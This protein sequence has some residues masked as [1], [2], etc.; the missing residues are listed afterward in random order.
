MPSRLLSES[1]L[2]SDEVCALSA[3]G[4][5]FYRRLLSVVDDFG[6]YDGRPSI[7]RARL[8]ALRI[9][10]VSESDIDAWLEECIVAG[11][12]AKYVVD[13]KHYLL[14]RGLDTARAKSSKYPP[15]DGQSTAAPDKKGAKLQTQVY[16]IKAE[17]HSVVKIGSAIC[18]ESRLRELQTASPFCL[19][20]LGIEPGGM[21]REK[22]LHRQFAAQRIRL[23]GEW[24]RIE[25]SLSEYLDQLRGQAK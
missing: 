3:G 25:G 12:V 22:E 2:S 11:L 24:F 1:I 7:L 10:D 5:V 9:D 6:R 17:G 21:P 8:Y 18:P 15:P 14:Y 4:E 23:D 16:F 13:G 20:L 19:I